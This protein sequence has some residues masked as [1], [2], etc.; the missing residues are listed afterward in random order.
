MFQR[1]QYMILPSLKASWSRSTPDLIRANAWSTVRSAAK[2][3]RLKFSSLDCDEDSNG[4][5]RPNVKWFGGTGSSAWGRISGV[6]WSDGVLAYVESYV[7]VTTVARDTLD[8]AWIISSSFTWWKQLGHKYP[9]TIL[10]SSTQCGY[11]I[12]RYGPKE[13]LIQK[14]L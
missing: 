13:I 12:F 9:S 3:G 1:F 6:E 4:T 2:G 11:N 14:V 8:S 10:D 7:A 5:C